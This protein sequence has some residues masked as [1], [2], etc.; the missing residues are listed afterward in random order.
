[1]NHK[2]NLQNQRQR[3]LVRDRYCCKIC[4]TGQ[5]LTKHHIIPRSQSGTE[6]DSN[7]VMLC[8]DCHTALHK[9]VRGMKV[10]GVDYW[11]FKGWCKD[12]G[13]YLVIDGGEVM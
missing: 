6:D 5:R 7:I 11:N 10:K 9:H 8:E 1:M 2:K 4:G 12:I 3:L 13:L